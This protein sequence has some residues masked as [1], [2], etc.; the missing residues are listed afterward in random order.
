MN[1]SL[2]L[3]DNHDIDVAPLVR[4]LP[5]VPA[6]RG[7]GAISQWPRAPERGLSAGY[8]AGHRGPHA[9]AAHGA[10]AG[11]K[12]RSGKQGGCRRADRRADGGAQSGG[13]AD[14]AAGGGRFHQHFAG[15]LS[16][17]ELRP[18]ARLRA[19]LRSRARRL[20]AGGAGGFALPGSGRVHRRGPQGIGP[21]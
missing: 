13:R 12:R 20:R 19:Y 3:G 15:D 2:P 17:P 18:A 21:P 16:Q 7:D 8:G 6:V 4:R 9:I 5:A 1:E 14:A 11:R 10:A